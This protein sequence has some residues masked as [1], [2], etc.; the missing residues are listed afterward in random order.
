MKVV[1]EIEEKFLDLAGGVSVL[2]LDEAD[3]QLVKQAVKDIKSS[4]DPIPIKIDGYVSD[5]ELMQAK[6]ALALMAIQAASGIDK[7]KLFVG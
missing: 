2:R 5:T 4:E 1:I 6:L 3:S 7:L